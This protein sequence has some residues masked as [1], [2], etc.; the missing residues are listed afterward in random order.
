MIP[1]LY[2]WLP[3]IFGCHCR[4]D[5]S[6]SYRGKQFP[7]CARCTGELVGILLVCILGWLWMPPVWMSVL[8]M[9]PML[10]DGFLQSLTK[11]ESKN[12]RRFITGLFFGIG[13]S[14]LVY[15][16]FSWLYCAGYQKGLELIHK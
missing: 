1:W 4:R 7:I 6:F 12:Y 14:V 10:I 9:V 3:I 16:W 15:R 5:R 13:I 2:K 11:Y 8:F